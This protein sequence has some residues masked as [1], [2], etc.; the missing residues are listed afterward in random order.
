MGERGR[1]AEGEAERKRKGVSTSCMNSLLN[2][3][4]GAYTL[5]QILASSKHSPKP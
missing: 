1:N 3:F 5:D 2:L 4:R